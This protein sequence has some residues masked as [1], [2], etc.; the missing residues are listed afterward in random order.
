MPGGQIGYRPCNLPRRRTFDELS[1]ALVGREEARY[2][3]ADLL[4]IA[5]GGRPAL[6][7]VSVFRS[8]RLWL[9]VHSAAILRAELRP[10]LIA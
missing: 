8:G 6:V 9:R 10:W 7:A 2:F 5:S 3:L 4:L 1:G